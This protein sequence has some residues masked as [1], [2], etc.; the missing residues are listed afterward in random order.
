MVVVKWF[1]CMSAKTIQWGKESSFQPM[2]LEQLDVH[3]LKDEVGPFCYTSKLTQNE[4]V[5]LKL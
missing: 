1:F 5:D 2:V 3:R 4:S